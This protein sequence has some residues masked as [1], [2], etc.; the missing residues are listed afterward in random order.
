[1]ANANVACG[2]ISAGVEKVML[3]G[4]SVLRFPVDFALWIENVDKILVLLS[5]KTIYPQ[6]MLK[7]RDFSIC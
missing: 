7:K 3:K 2:R 5:F 1:M 6:F 4:I